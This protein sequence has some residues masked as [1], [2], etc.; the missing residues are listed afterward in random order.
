M[1]Q[2]NSSV[3]WRQ[4]QLFFEG[5]PI[6]SHSAHSAAIGSL[7]YGVVIGGQRRMHSFEIL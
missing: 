1:V 3:D 4:F 6:T 5:K 7:A 2:A